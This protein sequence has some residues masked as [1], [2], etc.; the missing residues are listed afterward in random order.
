MQRARAALAGQVVDLVVVESGAARV[1]VRRGADGRGAACGSSRIS[2]RSTSAAGRVARSRDREPRIRCC[3]S[4]GANSRP[5]FEYPGGELRAAFRARVQRGLDRVLATRRDR[6][7]AGGPQGRDPRDRRVAHERS[8]PSA[9]TPPSAR[10][11]ADAHAATAPGA[12][13]SLEQSAGY[14]DGRAG[15]GRARSSAALPVIAHPDVGA[16]PCGA[17]VADA[18]ARAR[19]SNGAPEFVEARAAPGR[20][21]RSAA[22]SS[23]SGRSPAGRGRRGARVGQ[24]AFRPHLGARSR[25]PPGA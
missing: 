10:R 23:I 4:S 9:S 14:R 16:A 12:R 1:P 5:D 24:R 20:A 21:S 13:R 3:T 8:F 2:A 19:G 17:G 15:R 6:R 25:T 18:P 7:A 11:C 22:A